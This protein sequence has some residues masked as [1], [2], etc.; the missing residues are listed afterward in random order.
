[1][2][3]VSTFVLQALDPARRSADGVLL[4]KA[5]MAYRA[6]AVLVPAPVTFPHSFKSIVQ[7]SLKNYDDMDQ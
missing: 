2:L 3:F 6:S 5:D 1:M 7:T 4:S